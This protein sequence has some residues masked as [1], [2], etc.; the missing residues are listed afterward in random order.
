MVTKINVKEVRVK[1]IPHK[2]ATDFVRKNHYSGKVA[3]TTKLHF[4]CFHNGL[5][6]G[7]ISY[8]SSMSP[9]KTVGLVDTGYSFSKSWNMMLELNRMAFDDYLPK[10]SESR[11]LSITF[12]LLQRNA[13]HIKW[14]LS[15]SDA[16]ASGDGAIYRACGFYLTKITVNKC[17]LILPDGERVASLPPTNRNDRATLSRVCKKLGI[18]TYSGATV[19][20][21]LDAGAK[22]AEG[23][24]LRYIKLLDPSCKLNCPQLPYSAIDDVGAGMYRGKRITLA[25]RRAT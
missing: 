14:I 22:W 20:P 2:M 24:Q 1:V 6:H 15:Y 21:I 3:T 16:T 5:L 19:K 18:P 4:G 7:V 10:N 9:A 17:I 25:E 8:G 23:Y 12:R 11:C 13:P